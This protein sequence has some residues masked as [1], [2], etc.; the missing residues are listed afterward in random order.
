MQVKLTIEKDYEI[1]LLGPHGAQLIFATW[2]DCDDE[3]ADHARRLMDRH[4]GFG[5]A[6]VWQGMHLVRRV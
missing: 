3:A 5:E 1:R 4:P 2:K 6:E